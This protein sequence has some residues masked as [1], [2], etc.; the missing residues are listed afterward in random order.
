MDADI[1]TVSFASLAEHNLVATV[2]LVF[3]PPWGS[4][5]PSC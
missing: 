4:H 2:V 5:L 3:F 1:H